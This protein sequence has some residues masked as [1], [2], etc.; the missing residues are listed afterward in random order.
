MVFIMGKVRWGGV[1]FQAM[2]GYILVSQALQGLHGAGT[3][4]WEIRTERF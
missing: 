1:S 3:P 4:L 2:L